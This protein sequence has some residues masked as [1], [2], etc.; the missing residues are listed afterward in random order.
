[1]NDYVYETTPYGVQESKGKFLVR[2][3]WWGKTISE[4]AT[5]DEAQ[6]ACVQVARE[7]GYL[8]RIKVK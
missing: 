4:H 8:K 6:D 3:M 1:M 5:R 7:Q 2:Q